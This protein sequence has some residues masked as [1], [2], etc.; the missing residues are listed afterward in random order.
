MA[1]EGTIARSGVHR[2]RPLA[3]PASRRS[4]AGPD[5]AGYPQQVVR[6]TDKV[7]GHLIPLSTAIACLSEVA[8]GLAPAEDLFDPLPDALADVVARLSGGAVVDGRPTMLANV[9]RD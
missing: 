2:L 9:L 5:Q 8:D 6:S 1:S 4:C 3:P 7:G